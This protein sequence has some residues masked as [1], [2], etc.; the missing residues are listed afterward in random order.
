MNEEEVKLLKEIQQNCINQAN[1]I[2]PKAMN[3]YNMLRHIEDIILNLQQRIDKAIEYIDD[4]KDQWCRN[5]EV[6]SDMND[7]LS[8]LKGEDK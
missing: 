7:L 2:D 8:I 5:D 4:Y 1:Y 6:I 3:K